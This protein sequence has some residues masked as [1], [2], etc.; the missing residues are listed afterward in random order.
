M[1]YNPITYLWGRMMAFSE[2][3]KDD[4]SWN[5]KTVIGFMSFSVMTLY[6]ILDL[7]TGLLGMDLALH[8][9]IYNSFLYLTVGSFGI[10]GLEKFS[11][12]ERAKVGQSEEP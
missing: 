10:A 7:T 5:E 4:N 11:P 12:T 2:I 1:S 3:F 6:S 9:Y 8:E